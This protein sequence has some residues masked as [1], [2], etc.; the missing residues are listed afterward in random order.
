M[1]INFAVSLLVWIVAISVLIL[2]FPVSLLVWF[3]AFPFDPE[4]KIFHKWMLIHGKLFSYAIP[5]WKID[6]KGTDIPDK[7]GV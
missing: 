3:A 6:I 2:L 5:F 1:L 4:R 7:K